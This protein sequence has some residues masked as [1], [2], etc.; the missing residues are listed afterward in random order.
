M[1]NDIIGANNLIDNETAIY[2]SKRMG[3]RFW[4]GVV[5]T[6]DS[7]VNP[8]RVVLHNKVGKEIQAI[9]ALYASKEEMLADK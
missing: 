2:L 3:V 1:K 6:G 5:F 8:N 7:I 9:C 4:D